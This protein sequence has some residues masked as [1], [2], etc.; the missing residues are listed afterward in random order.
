MAIPLHLGINHPNLIWIGITAI[1]AFVAGM[2]VNLYRST[3][4]QQGSNSTIPDEDT[5]Q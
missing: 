2:G 3:D 1:L 5:Q 4:E